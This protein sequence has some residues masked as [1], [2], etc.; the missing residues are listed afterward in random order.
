MQLTLFELI[1]Y[2]IKSIVQIVILSLT[3]IVSLIHALIML[4]VD[5]VSCVV[6][7]FGLIP[8]LIPACLVPLF[9]VLIAHKI[10][11]YIYHH[12]NIRN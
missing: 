10:I 9:Y 5:L 8:W 11:D 3:G 4:I 6:N 2:V 7:I 1:A 12:F